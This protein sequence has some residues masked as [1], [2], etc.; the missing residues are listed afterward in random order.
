M[1]CRFLLPFLLVGLSAPVF[2]WVFL[3]DVET[4]VLEGE[5]SRFIL[6]KIMDGRPVRVCVD[7]VEQVRDPKTRARSGGVYAGENRRAYYEQAAG[8]V[9]AAYRNWLEETRQAVTKSGR[10]KEFKDLLARLP[11]YPPLQFVNVGPSAGEDEYKSCESYPVEALDLRVRATL[12]QSGTGGHATQTTRAFFTFHLKPDN[13]GLELGSAEKPL[14][15]SSVYIATHEAGH[16]LGL[17]D[18]Y[19]GD[20]NPVNS[21]AYT[22]SSFYQGEGVAAVMNRSSSITCD[23]VEGLVNLV[24]FF[25][26]DETSVRRTKGW[27]DLCGRGLVYTRSRA[28]KV[29]DGE[30]ADYLKWAKD[31]YKNEPPSVS[32]A[33]K[34]I[35][36]ELKKN[37]ASVPRA[38]MAASS[39]Q[40]GAEGAPAEKAQASSSAAVLN[41]SESVSSA[42]L[43][44]LSGPEAVLVNKKAA[45][46]NYIASHPQLL[47]AV[48]AVK[49]GT[50][51]KEQA[52][53]VRTYQSYFDDY[54]AEAK[55][56]PSL[57]GKTIVPGVRVCPICGRVIEDSNFMGLTYQ[58]AGVRV[59][60]HRACN[61]KRKAANQSIPMDKIKRYG[62]KL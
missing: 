14:D 18:L 39:L 17:G 12:Y 52:N 38:Q 60:V 47:A 50:A 42:G 22:L 15:R 56:N 51:D 58:K 2:G 33:R 36:E 3:N 29:D 5:S 7:V 23:D 41:G 49:N 6:K 44:Q 31:G 32:A 61:Q 53:L 37:L 25:S 48:E 34:K 19:M 10:K 40:S 1:K 27:A 30:Y 4:K 28:A 43:V 62:E 20:D 46:D 45:L 24:D 26:Q 16:T 8:V 11:Q 59:Y 21:R 9:S 35:A 57:S 55:S 13:S 54:K